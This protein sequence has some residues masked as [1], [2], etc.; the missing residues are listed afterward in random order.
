MLSQITKRSIT[1]TS[2]IR[3]FSISRI[4]MTEG[5]I[6]QGSDAFAEKERAVENLYIRKHEAEQLKE[7]KKKLEQ[8]KETIEKLEK[9]LEQSS[10]KE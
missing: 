9:E 3:N 6:P 5:A 2:F 10:H 1:R 7:L 8:Q 4:A